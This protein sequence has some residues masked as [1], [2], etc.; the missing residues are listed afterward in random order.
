MTCNYTAPCPQVLGLEGKGF[1]ERDA[2]F[3]PVTFMREC[4][5]EEEMALWITKT[6]AD[7][8]ERGVDGCLGIVLM[9][10]ETGE[11]EKGIGISRI[12]HENLV[13]DFFRIRPAPEGKVGATEWD[14][15]IRLLGAVLADDRKLLERGRE[16]LAVDGDVSAQEVGGFTAA[17]GLQGDLQ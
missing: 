13:G 5:T 10:S 1:S 2:G 3:L 8:V 6:Q 16:I 4:G 14:K 17:K 11:A 7:G 12:S 15:Q 9:K